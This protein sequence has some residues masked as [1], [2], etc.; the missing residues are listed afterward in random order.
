MP[1]TVAEVIENRRELLI[2]P[3]GKTL[4]EVGEEHCL[5]VVYRPNYYTGDYEAALR[6][7]NRPFKKGE[8]LYERETALQWG[9]LIL[10]LVLEWDLELRPGEAV[11]LTT[12]GVARIPIRA[13]QYIVSSIYE[14]N[15]PGK[16]SSRT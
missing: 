12:E 9:K 5:R 7:L 16:A 3:Q 10:D 6:R 13:M 4:E 15:E 1:L 14:D 8:T 11:P 2:P